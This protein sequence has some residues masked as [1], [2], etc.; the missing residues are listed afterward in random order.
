MKFV[1]DA[2]GEVL[3]ITPRQLGWLQRMAA[4]DE[5]GDS[6]ITD[7]HRY[8]SRAQLFEQVDRQIRARIQNE[9]PGM[10]NAHRERFE[11]TLGADKIQQRMVELRERVDHQIRTTAERFDATVVVLVSN[12]L[13]KMAAYQIE[14]M[15][16][17]AKKAVGAIVARE[18]SRQL[19][20]FL[21]EPKPKKVKRT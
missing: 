20:R 14:E 3:E 9:L 19:A 1:N 8:K 13:S 10:L 15:A 21:K 7:E 5:V 4:L 2:T 12:A 17:R 18:V 11:A 16:S 6:Q